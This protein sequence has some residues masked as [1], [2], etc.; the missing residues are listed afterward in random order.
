[1]ARFRTRTAGN[2]TGPT[3]DLELIQAG[4]ASRQPPATATLRCIE[5][6]DTLGIPTSRNCGEKWGTQFYLCDRS[7][8]ALLV[9][10][11][12]MFFFRLLLGRLR[13]FCAAHQFL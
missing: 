5:P 7:F 10:D 2:R 12:V 11:E 3:H 4:G 6:M 8:R 13:Q 1:M 9:Q